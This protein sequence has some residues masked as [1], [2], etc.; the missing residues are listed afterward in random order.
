V[1]VWPHLAIEKA[2]EK[3]TRQER[4]YDEKWLATSEEVIRRDKGICHICGKSGADTTDHKK[5][6][7]LG[8]SN[9][10]SNLAAAHRSCNGKK[11]GGRRGTPS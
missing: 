5:P 10:K 1:T 9:K 4:G 8:G 3:P 11:D 7:K 2:Y 6:K